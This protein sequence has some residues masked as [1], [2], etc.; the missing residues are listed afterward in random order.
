MNY[1]SPMNP[2]LDSDIHAALGGTGPAPSYSGDWSLAIAFAQRTA[3]PMTVKDLRTPARL[4][5]IA[6]K[7]ARKIGLKLA[8]PVPGN[9]YAINPVAITAP[10]VIEF[11]GGTSS[12]IPAKGYGKGYGSYRIDAHPIQRVEFGM[13]H[14]CNSAEIRTLVAALHDLATKCDPAT[15]KVLVRGDSQIAL[16][17]VNKTG[18]PKSTGSKNFLEAVANLH[19]ITEKFQRVATEWRTRKVSVAIFGH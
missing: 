3:V 16:R 12:N 8:G 7:H 10:I 13:G 11:D 6:L 18:L 19:A 9:V 14:S 4:C 15:T 2:D 5:E 17:W 1:L